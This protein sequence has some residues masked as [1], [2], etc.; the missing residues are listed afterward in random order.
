MNVCFCIFTLNIDDDSSDSSDQDSFNNSKTTDYHPRIR[1]EQK[2]CSKGFLPS[3]Y[4]DAQKR[5]RFESSTQNIL[6]PISKDISLILKEN[7]KDRI[8][9]SDNED[10]MENMLK[11]Q[12][13]DH[14]DRMVEIRE[15][16]M[17]IY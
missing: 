1:N 2:Y 14:L 8:T 12:K 10:Y 4:T 17:F 13:K 5:Y 11:A 7:L 6:S 15:E 3:K 9:N 16:V